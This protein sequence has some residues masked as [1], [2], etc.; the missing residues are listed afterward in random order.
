MILYGVSLVIFLFVSFSLFFRTDCPAAIKIL[1]TLLILF[2]NLKFV[3]Y[4]VLGGAFFSP[5]LPRPFILAMEALYGGLILLF[6][7]LAIWDFYLGV[8]WLMGKAGVPVPANLPKGLIKCVLAGVSMCLGI[9]GTYEAVKVPDPRTVELRLADLPPGLDGTV[10]VQLS[11]L[12]IG[13]LLK[14]DWLEETVSRVNALQPDLI[15]LTGD[16]VDGH[17]DEL[18]HEVEP[19]AQLK[20]KYGVFGV[21]GNHEYYWNVTEWEDALKNLGIRLLN[22]ENEPVEINNSI[23]VVAGLPDISATRFGFEGPD[24]ENA[25]KG[26]P[27]GLRL[28]L[29]HQPRN[30]REYLKLADIQLSGHTHG[31]LMFFLRPLVARF[32]EGFVA[33]LYPE[34]EN[35]LYVSPGTGLWNGF[36][37]RIGNPPEI[38][39][40]VLKAS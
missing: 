23:I 1:G 4:Q 39:R 9:W 11:D 7:L 24:I 12:H 33:G 34:G 19:L 10:I 27:A 16:Y 18:R 3:V 21:T 25:L 6:F 28:L 5:S 15:A 14:R 30:A 36:S 26:A 20:A 29:S 38:T 2:I 32:N 37:S 13:P 17:I 22:N 8:N 35:V 31:G 40:I